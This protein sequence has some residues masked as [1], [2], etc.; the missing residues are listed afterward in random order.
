MLVSSL[1]LF[2]ICTF[3]LSSSK[4]HIIFT[5]QQTKLYPGKPHHQLQKLSDTRWACHQT[6]V[7][8]ICCTFEAILST[9]QEVV[10]GCD[11]S[12]AA[13][14]NGILLQIKSFKYILCLVIFD[15][16]L[17]CSKG[18]SDVRQSTR[19][20]LGKVAGLVYQLQLEL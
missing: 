1:D 8:A 13:E 20:D 2:K 15:K 14:T 17:S 5:Q 9:L 3:F 6:A 16:L 7:N 12:R 4:C 11:G 10:D 18:L 19:L